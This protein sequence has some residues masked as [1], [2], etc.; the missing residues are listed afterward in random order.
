MHMPVGAIV[1]VPP[2]GFSTGE[3]HPFWRRYI[4]SCEQSLLAKSE[5]NRNKLEQFVDAGTF[6]CP[7]I[8]YTLPDTTT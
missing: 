3:R 6:D 7:V 2:T 8:R 5:A 4:L 1:G